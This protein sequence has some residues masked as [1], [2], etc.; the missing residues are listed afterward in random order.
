MLSVT[1]FC[2]K[3]KVFGACPARWD[4]LATRFGSICRC[5]NL[6]GRKA[7]RVVDRPSPVHLAAVLDRQLERTRLFRTLKRMQA[8][9]IKMTRPERTTPLA[10]PLMVDRLR[11][12]LSSEKLQDRLQRM[13]DTLEK[14][15]DQAVDTVER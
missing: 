5:R 13:L 8:A 4:S 9:S 11:E 10:F 1:K 15:A 14:H 7:A 12:K 2:R 3:G 6:Y